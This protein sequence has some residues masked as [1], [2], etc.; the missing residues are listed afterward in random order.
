MIKCKSSTTY[1]LKTIQ[2]SRLEMIAL[3]AQSCAAEEAFMFDAL[4]NDEVDDFRAFD[5]RMDQIAELKEAVL[6]GYTTAMGNE[7]DRFKVLFVKCG[8]NQSEFKVYFDLYHS[9]VAVNVFKLAYFGAASEDTRIDFDKEKP[10][11][12]FR[13]DIDALDAEGLLE[14]V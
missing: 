4:D 2:L 3:V 5:R 1:E 12:S 11:L 10:V 8:A 14:F 6:N 7:N 9:H 13:Y